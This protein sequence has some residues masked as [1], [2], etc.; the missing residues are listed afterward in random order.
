MKYDS[1]KF[2]YPPRPKNA[3]SPDN[4]DYWDNNSLLSQAKMNG[5][6]VTIY[7]NG[8]SII[9]MNRHGQRFSNFKIDTSE[10]LSLYNSSN[11]KWMVLNGEYMN[12]SKNDENNNVFN[13]KLVIFDILCYE[14]EYLIGSTFLE[15]IKLLD[16]I[17]GTKNSDKY[18]LFGITD[19]IYRVKSYFNGFKQIFDDFVKI[20]MVEGLVMKK[21]NA[22]LEIGLS[23]MN[24]FKTQLKC[25]KKTKLYNY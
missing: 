23:E 10:I 2:I 13:H 24:N 25:R 16:K 11:K 4:L 3:I 14:G 19:N 9:I 17:Y 1:Y 6:N 15:R 18:Y 8:D 7:T 5:S 22:K 20:D 21:I 12:K